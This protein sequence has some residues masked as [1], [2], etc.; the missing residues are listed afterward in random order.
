[1]LP[2]GDDT[3]SLVSWVHDHANV[4]QEAYE[5][6]QVVLEFEARPAVVERARAK[7]SDLA[8]VDA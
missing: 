1:V 6:E 4:E 5:G 7:A 2:L 8:A 3:M